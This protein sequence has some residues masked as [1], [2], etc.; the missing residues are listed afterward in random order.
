MEFINKN[1]IIE[2]SNPENSDSTRVTITEVHLNPRAIQPRHA[3]ETSEQIWYAVKGEGKLLLSNDEEK[4]FL[5]GDV[6]RFADGD[7]HGLLN[8]SDAEFVYLSVTS[9]PINFN[10]AY[11]KKQ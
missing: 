4:V 2:L 8:D 5:E 7:I 3:H 9:P 6:V 10:Y 1:T 11:E